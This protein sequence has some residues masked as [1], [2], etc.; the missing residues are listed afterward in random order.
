MSKETELEKIKQKGMKTPLEFLL[1]VMW[2][3]KV[4]VGVRIEAAKAAAPFVHKKMPL[5]IANTGEIKIIPPFV[6]SRGVLAEDFK[7]ELEEGDDL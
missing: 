3:K 6:P 4:T 7:D 2:N 1:A 5:E